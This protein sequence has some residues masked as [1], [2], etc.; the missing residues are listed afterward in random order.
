MGLRWQEV[1]CS[2]QEVRVAKAKAA[3]GLFKKE[4]VM[5]KKGAEFSR[6]AVS[7]TFPA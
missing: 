4:N 5:L 3:L 1:E 7:S 6:G 2:K